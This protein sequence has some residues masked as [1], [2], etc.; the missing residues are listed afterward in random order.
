MAADDS[1]LRKIGHAVPK[2]KTGRCDMCESSGVHRVA[3]EDFFVVVI[4]H[5]LLLLL[6]ITRLA[7]T[8]PSLSSLLSL[9]TNVFLVRLAAFTESLCL[10]R[11]N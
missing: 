4:D 10:Y 6:L 8:S 2:L 5:V 11:L 1:L 3:D 9:V 7:S